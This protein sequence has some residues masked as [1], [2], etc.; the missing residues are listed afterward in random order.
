MEG[1]AVDTSEP[2]GALGRRQLG[3]SPLLCIA[4][5]GRIVIPA[6]PT[7]RIQRLVVISTMKDGQ[8]RT[9]TITEVRFVPMTCEVG[10]PTFVPSDQ[11]SPW[12][13]R[14]GRHRGAVTPQRVQKR[15][16]LH[17]ASSPNNS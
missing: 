6:G 5:G 7:D 11:V 10:V 15:P 16:V 3:P 4:P 17:P 1:H 14:R 2:A 12:S 13:R 9:E 8:R